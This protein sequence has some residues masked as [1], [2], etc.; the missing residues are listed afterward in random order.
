M[1]DEQQKTIWPISRLRNWDKNP[2]AISPSDFE[3][4]KAQV[5]KFGQ[6]KPLLVTADGEV[7]GG[8]MRLRAFVEM[9]V[10]E[11]W[12]SVIDPKNDKEKLEYALSDNDR[13]GYYQDQE[14]AELIAGQPDIDQ[15]LFH[16]DVGHSIALHEVLT[17]FGPDGVEEDNVPAISSD[18]PQSRDGDIYQ[19]GPHRL[20]CGDATDAA[21]Y[22]LLMNNEKAAMV[23]T[24]PPYNV[25][26]RGGASAEEERE[27][28]IND[29]MS[30]DEFY[31]FLHSV[32]RN[33]VDHTLGA[34][35]VCMSSSELH[36]LWKAF[37][38]A[39]GHWSSY[40][41]WA[42]DRFTLSRTDYQQQYEPIMHGLSP[43]TL[44]ETQAEDLDIESS[45]ILY[46]WTRHAWY[47]G[48]KQGNVWKIDRP[49]SSPDH[50][51]MKPLALCARAIKNSSKPKEIVLDVF[52]GSGSTL[53][54]CH[55]LDRICYMMEI[56]PKY[57]D[58]IRKRYAAQI[59]SES[60]WVA[61]TPAV[62]N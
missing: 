34:F 24:D 40:I 49:Q 62:D 52:G 26:Y 13:A 58:V 38:D 47:G 15:S 18:P 55:Q 11:V 8:N 17:R 9:G 31:Q 48:R 7:L 61:A 53:I 46:G 37:I 4:L 25:D 56:S 50:P 21:N 44:K 41:I 5:S 29:K 35:Y 32:M 59:G 23:F 30:V 27:A 51:T 19:L 6:Y 42:K 54:A 45:P 33:M 3:R 43:E 14:L 10:T 1:A 57:C 28:I 39:G 22:H 12:V 2:R 20:M 16:V 36:T 60:D